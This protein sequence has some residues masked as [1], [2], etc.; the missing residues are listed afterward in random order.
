MTMSSRTPGFAALERGDQ[1]DQLIAASST[2]PVLIFKHSPTC[3][4]S[5]VAQE[6]LD[7]YLQ[8]SEPVDVHVVD[9]LSQRGLSGEIARRFGVRHQSPQVLLL[10]DSAVRWHAS[11]YSVTSVAVA[12]AVQEARSAVR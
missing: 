5:Y 7:V 1:L 6:E 8:D 2:R 10:V 9:V 3:G 11:H 12:R 4:T